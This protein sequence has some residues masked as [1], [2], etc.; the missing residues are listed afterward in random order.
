MKRL[1]LGAALT[2]CAH[3][4]HAQS[5]V[6]GQILDQ[7]TNAPIAGATISFGGKSYRTAPDGTFSIECTG[8]GRFSI[9]HIGYATV[10]RTLEGCASGLRI[11][12]EPFAQTLSSVEITATSATNRQMISQPRSISKLSPVEL[13]RSTGLFLDDAINANVPGMIMQRRAVSSGQQFNIRG[14]GNGVRGTNGVSSNFDGQGY[15]VY[16]NGIPVTDAEGISLMDDIDFGSIGNVEVTKGPAGTLYG[17][18]IAGAVNLR[19]VRPEAGKTSI[20]QHVLVGSNG[21]ERY[22]TTFQQGGERSSL[23]VNYGRQRSQGIKL[24]NN[25]RKDFVNV[26]ADFQPNARQSL[27]TYFGFSNSYDE[28]FGELTIDQYNRKDYS[29]NTNYLKN[30]AHSRVVSF[31][32]GVTHNYQFSGTVSNST[33]VFGTGIVSDASSAGGWTDKLP[34]NFGLRST[35]N[36]RFALGENIGLSGI[37]GVETQHQRAQ[38]IGFAMVADS[39]NPAGYNRIGAERSNVS[40]GTGTTSLFSE[41]TLSLPADVSLT[42]GLGWSNMMIRLQDRFFVAN[43]NRPNNRVADTYERTYGGMWSPHVALNKIFGKKISVYASYSRGYKAPVSSY[44]YIPFVTGAPATGTVARNLVP[45]V[46]DQFEIG[47]KG[48]VWGDRLFYELA[49]FHAEFRN[50]MTTVAVPLDPTTTAYSYIVNGGR[51]EHKGLEASVKAT[52]Y[53]SA[54]FFRQVSP[55][56]NLTLSD[57][58]YRDFRFMRFRVAPNA[59]K[60]S[61]VDYSGKRVAG[62]APVMAN[63]GVD[64]VTAPGIYLNAYYS[65]RDAV[66]LT[67]DNAADKKT[68]SYGILNAR[69]GY[70]RSLG[71]HFDLDLYAGGSNLGGIQYYYMVFV[72]QLPDAY[73]PAPL[74]T[75]WFGGIQLKYNF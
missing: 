11:S 22:T 61:T 57:F 33:T 69:L 32:S 14:Y 70:R 26:A 72:N 75:Q 46:G 38:T 15:K 29:G 34:V 41:W 45:E 71:T 49:L 9:S 37:S 31:R 59:S 16:L 40:T 17:L 1:L 8:G 23:L 20:G 52:A 60:D 54:G 10:S 42:A 56:A 30:N 73:L 18:A 50:K 28:R 43:N 67:S 3:Y 5:T 13:Q 6:Q 64:V 66:Y 55:F 62:V 44:F 58:H 39:A 47:S 53:R 19:T 2:A 25:S 21:L 7:S 27:N 36:T 51:Q 65:Y 24:H 63:A 12:L 4:A 68:S 35:F 74:N 48:S